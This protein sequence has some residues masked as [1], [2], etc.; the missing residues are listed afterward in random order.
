MNEDG[1][2]ATRFT[3]RKGDYLGTK[4]QYNPKGFVVDKESN[5]S[6]EMQFIWPFKA[7]YRVIYLDKNYE[8][9]IIGRSKRDYVWIMAREPGISE[10][11]YQ[12]LLQFIADLG[13]DINRIKKVPQK[14][15]ELSQLVDLQ[16]NLEVKF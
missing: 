9:T 1:S 10:E 7:E 16:T 6:W 12:E 4:K 14:W 13:Y 15:T 11:T 3:F 8:V 2:I 5:A